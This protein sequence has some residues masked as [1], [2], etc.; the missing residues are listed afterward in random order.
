MDAFEWVVL[1]ASMFAVCGAI[2]AIATVW[3]SAR[4]YLKEKNTEEVDSAQN[5]YC[6]LNTDS[7]YLDKTEY[8]YSFLSLK[9][10]DSTGNKKMARFMLQF[11]NHDFYDSMMYSGKLYFLKRDTHRSIQ[12]AFKLIKT[13]NKYLEMVSP[14]LIQPEPELEEIWLYCKLLEEYQSRI[15]VAIQESMRKLEQDFKIV[16]C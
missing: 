15:K 14:V 11:L 4:R 2:A 1:I 16:K 7:K 8:P 13:Y 9:T 10:T 12:Y 3:I 5:L 6:E